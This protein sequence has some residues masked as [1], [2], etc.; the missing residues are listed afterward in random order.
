MKKSR[1]LVVE[2]HLPNLRLIKQILAME[3]CYLVDEAVDGEEALKK[4]K[5][6]DYD[7]LLTDWLMPKVD[8]TKLI[9][10]VRKEL[11]SP[12]YIMMITAIQTDQAKE[13]ILEIGADEFISKPV[14][15][16]EL[17]ATLRE[18][19]ARRAQPLPKIQKIKTLFKKNTP[20]FVAVVIAS[21][22]GGYDALSQIFSAHLSE[23]A[24]Y[25]I[26]QHAPAYTLSNMAKKLKGL[27]N[28]KV[29]LGV[30]TQKIQSGNVYIAPGDRHLCI[31]PKPLSI[32]LNQDPKENFVRPSADPLFRS[33]ALVFGN[34]T[35]GIVLTGL[36]VDGTQG[37]A[38][39]K[40]A[41][42]EILVQD[43]KSAI[44]ARMPNSIILS[45]LATDVAS[46]AKINSKINSK[47]LALESNLT[48]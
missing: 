21:S 41:G 38:H 45:G 19:L 18:G 28:L 20:P 26:A 6:N 48:A 44:A 33:A 12:P 13:K 32:K 47:I 14:R 3:D 34:C 42:G 2:D 23:K 10:Q 24:A 37:A 4:I 31:N 5:N 43:P 8:G 17:L 39:I 22:T 35:L 1:I 46:L 7:A 25:F 15:G 30:D 16:K 27:T 40:A 9:K 11:T 29:N 36:G